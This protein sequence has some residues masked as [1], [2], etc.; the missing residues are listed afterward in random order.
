MPLSLMYL[1]RRMDSLASM[2]HLP[3]GLGPILL[4]ICQRQ[5]RWEGCLLDQPIHCI[6]V[7]HTIPSSKKAN[8]SLTRKKRRYSSIIGPF[9]GQIVIAQ[10]LSGRHPV[11]S[12]IRHKAHDTTPALP[13]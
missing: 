5:P 11:I 2:G 1:F 7:L 13:A 12:S 10:R 8:A 9:Q 4:S 3:Q 6:K